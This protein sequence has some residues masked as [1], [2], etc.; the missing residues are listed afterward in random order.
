M[1]GAGDAVAS[2]ISPEMYREFARPYERRVCEAIHNCG[3]L[4][5][6]HICGNT[7]ALLND[8]INSGADLFNVDHLVDFETACDVY[9]RAG[10]CFKGNL[11]PVGQIM[12]VEAEECERL[13]IA[14]MKRAEGNRYM[15]SAGCKSLWEPIMRY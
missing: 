8:M 14:C 3:G 15:L 13:S 5:K 6:L 11:D 9:G 12:Q 4:V 7:T 1:I 10:K 2:L